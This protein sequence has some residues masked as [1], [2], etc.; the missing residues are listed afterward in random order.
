MV[1]GEVLVWLSVCS[2]VQT[3][4]IVCPADATASQNPIISCIV[5]IQ[6]G[7]AFLVPAYP[8]YTGKEA[9]KR[10]Q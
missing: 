7:F 3:V 6:T 2:E 9:I 10:V 4:C 5:Y 1:S 8:G